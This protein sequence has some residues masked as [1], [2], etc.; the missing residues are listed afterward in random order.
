LVAGWPCC[1][2]S[3]VDT[4][5]ADWPHGVPLEVFEQ[6]GAGLQEHYRSAIE[7]FLALETLGSANAQAELR[8]LKAR[9]FERGE[10]SIDALTH[11]LQMLEVTDLR[12]RLHELAMPSLWIA[13]R[14]DR[15]VSPEA[16]RWASGESTQSEFVELPSGHAPFI[17]HPVDT[18]QAIFRFAQQLPPQ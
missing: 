17:N 7:R 9:V 3:G 18:A 8:D 13:G 14:R 15:L 1:V 5:A 2:A 4:A 11:G 6:F 10:P 16:M 12:A